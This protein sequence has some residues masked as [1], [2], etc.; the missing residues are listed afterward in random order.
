[1]GPP[2]TP[3]GQ[4]PRRPVQNMTPETGGALGG[5]GLATVGPGE[6]RTTV[7]VETVALW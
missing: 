7:S 5:P 2:A 6:P 1:M 4:G 3:R